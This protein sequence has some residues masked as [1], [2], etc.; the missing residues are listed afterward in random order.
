MSRSVEPVTDSVHDTISVRLARAGQRYTEV[1]RALIGVLAN[2]ERPLTLPEILAHAPELAQSSA[3][4]NLGVLEEV[5]VVHRVMG[6]DEL[7]RFEL[8]DEFTGHH[9]HAVCTNC[10][11]IA[12]IDV[13]VDDEHELDG[14]LISAAR[15]VGFV[16]TGHRVDIVG[17]CPKCA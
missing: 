14:A 13:S 11:T 4:R 9:H 8:A 16:M 1:R 5:G 12:D 10:G 2:T 3:Y 6:A 15:S 17:L 7:G